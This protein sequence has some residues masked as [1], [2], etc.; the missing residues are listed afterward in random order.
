MRLHGPRENPCQMERVDQALS[1]ELLPERSFRSLVGALCQRRISRSWLF[2]MRN[3]LGMTP[4]HFTAGGARI[5]AYYARLRHSRVSPEIAKQKTI[6][7]AEE[8]NL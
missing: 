5:M 3:E 4:E 7:F 8:H 1:V 6:R 2:R